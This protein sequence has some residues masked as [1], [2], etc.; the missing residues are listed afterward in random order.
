MT[1]RLAQNDHDDFGG[2]QRDLIATG[3]AI[4]RRGLL[5]LAAGVG[6]GVAAFP[7][8]GCS[9]STT[10]PSTTD[11]TTGTTGG[12]VSNPSS[13]S[14]IPNETEGPYPGDGSNGPN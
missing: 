3:N 7:L 12:G 14:K 11:T 10:T 2:L 5:R 4:D 9:G 6:F 1:H 8:F 13:C